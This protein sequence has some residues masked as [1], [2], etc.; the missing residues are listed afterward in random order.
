MD[1]RGKPQTHHVAHGKGEQGNGQQQHGNKVFFHG[2]EPVTR[3]LLPAGE[4]I[5]GLGQG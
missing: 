4:L 5:A 2:L 1:E 3:F